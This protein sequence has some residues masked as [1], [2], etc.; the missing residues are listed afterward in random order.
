MIGFI[1]FVLGYVKIIII[2]EN[3]EIFINHLIS[4]NV[5]VWN[6]EHKNNSYYLCISISDY[7]KIRN[8]RS[9]IS[10]KYRTKVIQKYGLKF[11]LIN[12]KIRIGICVG[13][14]LV[15][16][17][18]I[19][20]SNFIWQIE[21]EG[22]EKILKNDVIN[23]CTE[24]G[25]TEGIS[26][27][28]IDTYDLSHKIALKISDIAWVSLNIE[29]SKLTLNIS[30]EENTDKEN[31]VTSN[32]IAKRDGTIYTIVEKRGTQNVKIGQ[33]VR[34]GEVLISCIESVGNNI[35]Y[36]SASG[37]I[38]ADTIHSFNVKVEKN[39]KY[40]VK[41]YD[42]KSKN[43]FEFF[44]IK[45]PLYLTGID[46]Y[47]DTYFVEKRIKM[48]N[49]GLPISFKTRYFAFS[50]VFEKETSKELAV[51]MAMAKFESELRKDNIL[52]VFEN[53]VSVKEDN[54]VYDITINAHCRENIGENAPV[55]I[56]N[57]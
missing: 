32:I 20:L 2:G 4:N 24:L 14:I 9:K 51:N 29:G 34:K 21:V 5:A 53:K 31:E 35:R 26:K 44:G 42:F 45:F 33:T 27:R 54:N 37:E 52:S 46:K 1:R 11:R 56:M 25:I 40:R 55:N 43:A 10:L 7:I 50:D 8:I 30:E 48:F 19:L 28:K 39:I 23:V 13:I 38:I 12:S 17:I 6:I 16:I 3:P 36:V 47:D 22:I 57:Y 15:F 49:K 41:N 18:N